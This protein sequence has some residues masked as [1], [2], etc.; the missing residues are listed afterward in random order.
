MGLARAP[1]TLPAAARNAVF[2][3][4]I[5]NN[6]LTEINAPREHV[7]L[8]WRQDDDGTWIVARITDDGLRAIG[9]DPNEGDVVADTAPDETPEESTEPAPVA[10]LT[11]EIALLDQGLAAPTA[12]PRASLRDAAAAVLAAW[13]D[14]GN[15]EGDMISA[16]AAPMEALR[17]ALARK[18]GRPMRE[19]GSPPRRREGTKLDTSDNPGL[20]LI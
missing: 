7:G 4:L 16:L 20:P 18:P 2:R 17:D 19:P 14:E 11:E 9:I 5:K 10:P 12:T 3:S 13:D 1:K 6:L 15:R 8:G